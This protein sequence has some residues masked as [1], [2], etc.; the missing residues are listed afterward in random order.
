MKKIGEFL[1][2]NQAETEI[3]FRA[4]QLKHD[5][6]TIEKDIFSGKFIVWN[7]GK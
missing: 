6:F 7:M 2:L 1:S 4:K 5:N 3:Y